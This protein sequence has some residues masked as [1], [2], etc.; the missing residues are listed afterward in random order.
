MNQSNYFPILFPCED[1]WIHKNSYSYD[2]Y[3]NTKS[4]LISTIFA[5]YTALNSNSGSLW[6]TKQIHAVFDDKGILYIINLYHKSK[7]SS[8]KTNIVLLHRKLFQSVIF[9]YNQNDF[10]NRYTTKHIL[11]AGS[12]HSMTARHKKVL[13]GP[14]SQR[15]QQKCLIGKK[16]C[17]TLT[18][19]PSDFAT[20]WPSHKQTT[21][22]TMSAKGNVAAVMQLGWYI[23]Y[24]NIHI[25]L[26]L[27]F[28]L[29]LQY[30]V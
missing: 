2:I 26:I 11:F 7:S 22:S 18:T 10:K 9:I 12:F 14:I 23:F 8:L 1:L 16:L 15:P 20:T 5:S 25:F 17:D 13:K 24:Y 29:P 3:V 6:K 30:F 4:Y 28:I 19:H 27:W 21:F